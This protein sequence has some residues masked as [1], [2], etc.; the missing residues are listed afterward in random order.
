MYLVIANSIRAKQCSNLIE[1]T[2][3]NLQVAILSFHKSASRTSISTG[4][5]RNNI[6]T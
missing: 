2:A 6:P 4:A 1:S 5:L 3:I